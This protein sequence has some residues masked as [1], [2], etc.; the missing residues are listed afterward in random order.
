MT[1]IID[2][3]CHT[4]ASDGLLSP[5]QLYERAKALNI[6]TL[7]ITDHD[8]VAA[9]HYLRTKK[10]PDNKALQLITGMELS[11]SWHGRNIHILGLNFNLNHPKLAPLISEQT[12]ARDNR[13]NYIADHL[14]MVLK[15][16]NP[17][18]KSE[19]IL[20]AVIAQDKATQPDHDD[21]YQ[22][23]QKP[24]L[25][26]PHFARWL[27]QQG[28]VKDTKKAFNYYLN[29]RHL[30]KLSHYWMPMQECI[31]KLQPLNC[32]IVLAHPARYRLSQKQLKTLVQEFQQAGGHALEVI[33]GS[34]SP[35]QIENIANL[36]REFT[37]QAS[38]GSDFHMPTAYRE[39]GRFQQLP[40]D[41]VP[42]WQQWPDCSLEYKSDTL[43]PT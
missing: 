26:R 17:Q 14:A 23:D 19:Q 37:L 7:A 36:C 43:I 39:L 11:T 4:N 20:E 9:H 21:F 33:S 15:K 8:T 41:L 2:L 29:D 22:H 5:I 16:T 27:E 6:T 10:L 42:V 34:Q 30:K 35:E 40:P 25:G 24:H 3:H 13:A 18:L 38:Q 28:L 12:L 1:N 32:S 31:A